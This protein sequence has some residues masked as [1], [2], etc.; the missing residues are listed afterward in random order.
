MQKKKLFYLFSAVVCII[1]LVTAGSFSYKI[2]SSY[3]E[4]KRVLT[5]LSDSDYT[6]VFL[7]M[8][9][10]SPFPAEAFSVNRGVPTLKP[11]YCFRNVKDL[12]AA[13]QTVFCSGNH[14]T[15][16][17]LG[18][19][20]F[21]FT[22]SVS[23]PPDFD[24]LLENGLLNLID[25][26]PEVSF[27]VLFSFPS[28]DFWRT[29]PESSLRQALDLYAKL[30]DILDA[31]E[32]ISMYYVGG[33]D[34]LI[35]NPS[36]YNDFFT[37]N[38]QVAE[39][40][41]LYTFCDGV[42]RITRDNAPQILQNALHTISAEASAPAE[43][44]DLSRYD[45]ILMGDSIL[46]NDT[47]SLS[48][49]DIIATFSGASVFNCSQ[50]GASAAKTSAEIVCFPEIVEDFLSGQPKSPDTVYGQGIL[51]YVSSNHAGQKTCFI[52]HFGVNDYF[53]GTPIKD[54][55]S[56]EDIPTY[57]GA[58]RSA[59]TALK[60]SYPNAMY[61]IM[62]PGRITAFHDGTDLVN[63]KDRLIDYYAAVSALADELD[64]DYIDLY[65][66]FPDGDD[67]IADVLLRDGVH[68]NE[69]GRFRLSRK[70]MTFLNGYLK[71]S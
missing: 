52:I 67:E 22:Q 27:D 62:G 46:A 13:L 51:K 14:M 33:E 63:G 2:L 70:I 71:H 12:N 8:Y 7:S 32:N 29:L 58:M 36:N 42:F 41:F 34:W 61:I 26:N 18:L 23:N 38:S 69:H 40:I 43:Y 10:T 44:P 31:K 60:K 30:V 66:D 9:N 5:L 20:P 15:N 6:S 3:T 50:G 54:G 28:M 21:S 25:A 49:P 17:F 39:K 65:T 47:G 11:D 4:K 35:C 19:D 68:Y 45:I 59:V 1:L 16:V 56:G 53:N 37:P 48:I 55:E 64:V 57:I 24:A